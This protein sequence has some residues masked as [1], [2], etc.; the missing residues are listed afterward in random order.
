[1]YIILTSCNKKQIFQSLADRSYPRDI[2]IV[3]EYDGSPKATV[4][5]SFA[6]PSMDLSHFRVIV[7]AKNKGVVFLNSTSDEES[8]AV[9][10]LQPLTK[11][12][13]TVVAEYTDGIEKVNSVDFIHSGMWI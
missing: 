5:W 10:N 3:P 9:E 2:S 7:K 11:H 4:S 6:G 12:I 8:I 1:M 13:V